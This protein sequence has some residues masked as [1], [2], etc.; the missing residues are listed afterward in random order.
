LTRKAYLFLLLMIIFTSSIILWYSGTSL[1]SESNNHYNFVLDAMS[2]NAIQVDCEQ[3]D[4]ISGSFKSS[5]DGSLYFGD[6]QKYDNW[7]F[8]GIEFYILNHSN[9][10]L[11]SDSNAFNS[12]YSKSNVME[13]SWSFIVESNDTWYVVYYNNSIYLKTIEGT[14]NH[15]NDSQPPSDLCAY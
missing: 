13:L 5:S 11:F 3:E 8:V 6:E 14:I 1:P 12:D 10:V 2:W 7:I 4:I 15:T 9:Y